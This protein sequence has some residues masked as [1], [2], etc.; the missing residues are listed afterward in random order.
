MT[1]HRMRRFALGLIGLVLIPPLLWIG[2]VVVA[3]TGWARRHV[4]SALEASSGRSVGL[5][6]L[7]VPLF[8]GVELTGLAFGSP[9]NTEDP[10]L[11]AD[12]IRLDIGL[13]QL[14]RGRLEPTAVV[15]HGGTIRVLRRADGSLE[16]ADFILPPPKNNKSS[17][18]A[19]HAPQRI[20]VQIRGGTVTL[21]DEPSQ[22][23]LHLLNLEGDGVCEG[24]RI[25]IDDLRGILNGGPFQFSGQ[26]DR[27]GDEPT[28][29]AR[30]HAEKVVLD[31]GMRLLR[32]AVPVLAGASLDLKGNLATDLYL[33]GKGK[34]WNAL[35]RSL[36]GHGAVALSPI[37]LDG[38][39][40]FTELS[41]IAELQRQG[42]VASIKSDF[43]I[44]NRRVTTD[45]FVLDIGRT[46]MALSGWT[47][48]DGRIDYRINLSGLN[49][50]LPD[51]A[52]RFL[53]D[54]N[55]DLKRLKLLTL[56][57]TVNK[58]VVQLNGVSL[59]RD[60]LRE[61]GIHVNKKDRDKLRVL[62]KKLIDELVR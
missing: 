33:Q 39:P 13:G 62:G 37:D 19:S 55:V 56:Q 20:A 58:M 14:L 49:D 21:I 47:D 9:Q 1:F 5:K 51:K 44:A 52:K 6:G 57:G 2:V 32:Y 40:I 18:R 43:L 8:G 36:A 38:A 23:C 17:G 54:F 16:L 34:T 41:K 10:W 46:P 12:K 11:N 42:R 25:V 29:E 45:H 22:T 3:Q 35:S 53:S 48:F 28:L 61:A 59:D 27:T 31:D 7:S 50:Q 24:K 15:M 26:L 4:I 30:F 60:L